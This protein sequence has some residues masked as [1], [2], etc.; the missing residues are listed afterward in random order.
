MSFD[1]EAEAHWKWLEALIHKIYVDAMKHGFGHG[2]EEGYKDGNEG[3][4][5]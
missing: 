2:Y 1:E 5:K 4:E 3:H